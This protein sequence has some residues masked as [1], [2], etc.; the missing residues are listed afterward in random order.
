MRSAANKKRKRQSN[1]GS[2]ARPVASSERNQAVNKIDVMKRLRP[3]SS[4]RAY[5]PEADSPKGSQRSIL[6]RKE[7]RSRELL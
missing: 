4:K 7:V 2:E 6:E 3:Q 1:P 5:L